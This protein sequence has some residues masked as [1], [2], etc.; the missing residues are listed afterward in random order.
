MHACLPPTADFAANDRDLVRNDE[1]RATVS[2]PLFTQLQATLG[3]A[4]RLERE[5]GGGGM[6]RVFVADE[7]RLGRKVVVKLLSPDLAQGLSAER[8]EREIRTVAGL[9]QANIVPVLTAGDTEGL[10]FYTMPFVE[11]ESLRA[12]LARGP[13]A[14]AE[15]VSVLKDVSKALA[16]A[17][18]RGVVHRDIKPDNVLIS[19]GTAV[20]TDF[21]IAKAISAART[22]SGGATLTQVGTSIGTPAYMA[23]EQ[24]AGDAGIDSRA[25]IYALGAMAYELL[26]GQLVFPDRTAPRMLAAHMSEDPRPL[27]T[28]RGDVP[29]ALA[30]LVMRCLAKDP[31]NRPQ[32]AGDVVRDLETMA[33]GSATAMPPILLGGPAMF[34]KA[35][36][37]YAASFVVVAVIAKAAIV[38]IGLPEWVFP[39]SL[40]VMGLGLP[41]VLWTGY[42]QRVTRR[43][44]TATPTFT[45]GGTPTA[46]HGK[47]ATIALKA[48]PHVSWY[49][50]ARGGLYAF[51]AF[52]AMIGLFMGLR[53][54]GVGPFASLLASGRLRQSEPILLTDF[55][56]TNVDSAL[57]RVVSDAVRAG[58]TGSSAFT[59][60]QP[61]EI[62][63]TL[64]QMQREPTTRIDS[65]VAR[66]IAQR[67]NIKAIVDGDVTGVP[68]GYIVSIRLV[69]ADSGGELA[70]FRET[71]DGPRGLIDAADKL[72][73]QLRAKAGESLRRV[74]ATPPLFQATTSSLDALRK[75]SEAVRLNSLGDRKSTDLARD[76]VALDSTFAMAWTLLAAT[77][78][79]Y[80]APRS[81]IDTATTQAYRNRGRL[82]QI[83]HDQVVGRYF[84]MG[85]GRDRGKAIAAYEGMLQRGDSIPQ[86]LINLG[87]LL[88]GRRQ[89][90]RAESLNLAASRLLPGTATAL[91][92]AVE[93]ELNQGKFK[94]AAANIAELKV[95][96]VGYGLGR[97]A[98]LFALQGD[99]RALTRLA[100]STYR[101]GDEPRRRV[102]LPN[103]RGLAV[104]EGR[105]RDYVALTNE[106]SGAGATDPGFPIR[107]L[108][109]EAELKGPSPKIVARLDSVIG[110]VPFKDLPMVDRP[111]LEAAVTLA[112]VGSADKAR[113][114]VA[115]YRAEV[116]DTAL[117]RDQ[118]AE[119]HDVLGEIAIADRKP[120]DAVEEFR[121]GDIGYDGAPAHECAPCLPLELGQA[122]DAAA[123]PDSAIFFLERY[124]ATP[125][126]DKYSIEL[127]PTR[128]PAI[129]ERLG[130]LY[131]SIGN[132]D[133]AVENYRAFI[134]LWKNADP[135]LQ[136]RVA[137][138]RKRLARLTPVE[139]PRP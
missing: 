15:V 78:S 137:D 35:L 111:Y 77:L 1:G 129:R 50:T 76:A 47:I 33:S 19:G 125:F 109:R 2:G 9:Q 45:P 107:Q 42:V 21:G 10:P 53:A 62:V 106:R 97:Q 98:S 55:R 3:D 5:L 121:R 133:K 105:W 122:F 29:A 84:A 28:L 7:V 93:M 39:G 12:R 65:A 52:V 118:L 114:M 27:A 23:P 103:L 22:D 132:T 91:G 18:Q 4:Y 74:N 102:G 120:L 69:R 138:A 70:S 81:A 86:V 44:M 88:R 40:I 130:Q 128:V 124:L 38:G 6:S 113:A 41:V 25:D 58:L 112:L 20:V 63:A 101:A 54:V 67:K 92:N 117:R 59:L 26:S 24:A 14:V 30:D 43:A 16:Y 85:P 57:G 49:R 75:Y 82:P 99:Y 126:W 127:D 104:Q 89:F 119:L 123:K 131:E 96:V 80:G 56:T 83:E 51:V 11:G 48:A 64:R 94:D 136:P 100:D 8:F 36:A 34:M 115:R 60:T 135:D 73:R 90:A 134:E 110:Q 31:A 116:T 13:L 95:R 72:A 37:I 46:T 61:A 66:E 32:S 108:R 17:H 68:G 139:K 71:G 79:N 87:E